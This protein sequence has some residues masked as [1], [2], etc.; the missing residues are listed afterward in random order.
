MRGGG[1]KARCLDFAHRRP[2]ME[3][4]ENRPKRYEA[5]VVPLDRYRLALGGFCRL[6]GRS[7]ADV[8][9]EGQVS[10]CRRGGVSDG[11]RARDGYYPCPMSTRSE[12][13][14][15]GGIEA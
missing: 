3:T 2:F 14:Q 15:S 12:T 7:Q 1:E 13:G 10:P 5:A 6:Q 4:C 8:G 11:E 9:V